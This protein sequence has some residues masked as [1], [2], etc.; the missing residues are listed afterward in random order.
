MLECKKK[1]LYSIK[2]RVCR[3]SQKL[4][5]GSNHCAAPTCTHGFALACDQMFYL[6]RI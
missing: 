2:N 4:A 5:A 3:L 1:P 6:Y